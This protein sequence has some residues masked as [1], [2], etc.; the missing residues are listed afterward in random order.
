MNGQDHHLVIRG[1]EIDGVGEPG[2]HGATGLDVN[3]LEQEGVLDD[4][5]D[6]RLD[7]LAELSSHTS[8]ARLVPRPHGE[9]V[10]LGLRPEDNFAWHAL[11]Q[12]LGP[13]VGPRNCRFRV[14]QVFGPASIE[15]DT[16]ACGEL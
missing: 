5:R 4:S 9:R 1:P 15:F 2:Q 7:S 10:V 14:A 6:Q 11:P 16:L 12:Q 8:T 3:T 13:N